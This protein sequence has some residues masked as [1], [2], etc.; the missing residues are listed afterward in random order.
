MRL[1]KAL[2][3]SISLALPL[4][5]IIPYFASPR[6]KLALH[7]DAT[8]RT[9]NDGNAIV[10]PSSV[11][12]EEG[13]TVGADAER[14]STTMEKTDSEHRRCIMAPYPAGWGNAIYI[15]LHYIMIARDQRSVPCV[16]GYG[17]VFGTLFKNIAPCPAEY[18]DDSCLDTN[19]HSP[20]PEIFSQVD[21]HAND[22]QHRLLLELNATFV[23]ELL[24]RYSL[25]VEQLKSSCAVHVR[26][27]DVFF[28]NFTHKP[29][30][31]Y[32]DRRLCRWVHDET[33]CFKG[34]SRHVKERCPDAT[35][36]LYLAS[37]NLDFVRYF[38]AAEPSRTIL[39][40][41]DDEARKDES[42]VHVNDLASIDIDTSSSMQLLLRD[43]LALAIAKESSATSQSTFSRTASLGFSITD[44][45]NLGNVEDDRSARRL[46]GY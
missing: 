26:F 25:S 13:G 45:G 35:T 44:D 12:K 39:P 7:D 36:P 32:V 18:D 3:M 4:V 6:L 19:D 23:N 5:T 31:T 41:F 42:I 40:S 2:L 28:R 24:A 17:G 38:I 37:D 46:R 33:S 1:F 43:W 21:Q 8:A 9:G 14:S 10:N 30:S 29:N 22:P 27:G 20:W 15:V 34:V 11:T 16:R